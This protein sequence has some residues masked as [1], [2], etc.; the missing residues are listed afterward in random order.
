MFAW[1]KIT[2]TLQKHVNIENFRRKPREISIRYY[3]Y[4]SGSTT[5]FSFKSRV[6]CHVGDAQTEQ[7]ISREIQWANLCMKNTIYYLPGHDAV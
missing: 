6:A 3:R 2:A 4:A 1:A 5:Q 7:E